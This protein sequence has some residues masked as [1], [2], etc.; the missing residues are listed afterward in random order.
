MNLP[1]K[2]LPVSTLAAAVIAA[3]ILA[4]P[5]QEARAAGGGGGGGGGGSSGGAGGGMTIIHAFTNAAM[6]SASL[7]QVGTNF[8]GTTAGNGG[9]VNGTLFKITATT[10]GYAFTNLSAFNGATNGAPSGPLVLSSGGILYG[11]T[12]MSVTNGTT[13]NYGSIFSLTPATGAF[14]TLATFNNA[15]G[16]NPIGGLTPGANDVYYGVTWSGGA[17]GLGTVFSWSPKGGLTNLFSFSGANGSYPQA[18]LVSNWDGNFYGTTSQGGANGFGTVFQLTPSG[19]VTSL[20]SFTGFNGSGPLGMVAVNSN[21]VGTT[22]YGGNY[23]LGTVFCVN[24]SGTLWLAASFDLANGSN[25]NS[26]L[27]LA[28]D[29]FLYGTTLQGGSNGK[30]V[31]FQVSTNGTA[32][33][34]GV[35][36]TNSSNGKGGLLTNV[37]TLSNVFAFDGSS[38][39]ANPMGGLIQGSDY[40]L[41]GTTTAGSS[42]GYGNVFSF[43]FPLVISKQPAD[44]TFTYKSNAVFSVQA[45]ASAGGGAGGLHYQWMWNGANITNTNYA[46]GVIFLGATTSKLTISNEVIYDVGSY[47]VVVSN[48][49]SVVT[50]AVAALSVPA[51]TN[52]ITSPKSKLV[53]NSATLSVTGSDKVVKGDMLTNVLYSLN[54]GPLTSVTPLPGI[55]NWTKWSNSV[56]LTPGSNT[57]TA[58]ALDA[59]GHSSQTSTV[60]VFYVTSSTL[61]LQTNGS[62]SIANSAQAPSLVIGSNSLVVA[63]NYTFK[64]VPSFD[65][66]FSNWTESYSTNTLTLT[67]NPLTF[68]M[69]SN[70]TLTANFVTNP[71]IAAGAAGAYC[72]L[73]YVTNSNGLFDVTNSAAADSSGLLQNLNVQTNGSY[74]A[75]LYIGGADFSI[76]GGFDLSG[77][78]T[79]QITNNSTLGP[80]TLKMYL[81][82]TN[83]PPQV[84]GS[85]SGTNGGAWT[86]SLTA[87]QTDTSLAA[88]E[89]NLLIPPMTNS[90]AGYG[91]AL[92][93]GNLG[94][95]ATVTG[96]LADGAAFSENTAISKT[97][98]L[99]I[100]AAPYSNGLLM[101]L[102]S[103]TNGVPRGNL[104]WIR[105]AAA[106]SLFTNGFAD[107]ILVQSQLWTNPP[108]NTPALPCSAGQLMISNSPNSSANL[109]FYVAV[110]NNNVLVKLG[111]KPTNSLSGSINPNTGLLTVTIGNGYGKPATTG[112]GIVLQNTNNVQVSNSVAGFIATATNTG[113][114]ILQTNLVNVAPIILR[115][116]AGAKF[117]SGNT[118]QFSVHAIGS[119]PLSY[120][121]QL[122]GTNLND[123]GEFSGSASNTLTVSN[124]TIYDAGTYSVIVTNTIKA[125]ASSNVFLTIPLPGIA[126]TSPKPKF[127]TNN[128]SLSV[129]GTATVVNGDTVTNVLYT[130]NN[131]PWTSA[132]QLPGTANWSNWTATVTLTP[133]SNIF[134]ACALDAL[135]NSSTN[136][137]AAVFYVTYSTLTLLTNGYGANHP[138]FANKPDAALRTNGLI[139]TNL[140]VGTNYTVT[141]VPKANNLFSNWTESY[142]TNTLTLTN[143]PLT[144][145]MQSNT[146]LTANFVTNPFMAAGAAG[147]YN[148]LFYVTDSNGAFDVTNGGAES[149]GLLG[150]L[151][152]GNMGTYSGKLYIGGTNYT[153]SGGFDLA[154]QANNQIARPAGLGPVSL[155]MNLSFTNN[156]PR[157]AGTVQGTN[158][159]AWTADLTAEMA[160]SNL[161]SAQYT[162][163]IPGDMEPL[164]DSPPGDG[165]ALITNHLGTVILTGALADGAS[166]SQTIAESENLRLPFYAAPYTNGLFTN[167]LL[168]GW[169]DLSGGAPA[170]SL[171]WIC[172]AGTSGLFTNGYTN[173]VTVQSSAWTD[174]GKTN[175]AISLPAGAPGYALDISYGILPPM[176]PVFTVIVAANNAIE[177]EGGFENATN[178]LSGSI[179]SK[180][181]KLTVIYGNGN[182]TNTTSAVGA[183]LQKQSMGGGFFTNATSAGAIILEPSF[184]P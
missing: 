26:P 60:A 44:A 18:G 53:T 45:T 59:L 131:G 97:G 20:A 69:E 164:A 133:G 153:V 183:I 50:S 21:L 49:S 46:D 123:V 168:T 122:D 81:N 132:T 127:V 14:S 158:G 23:D 61:T 90:P 120:Q 169:L 19:T 151:T 184:G 139:Y 121:W 63:T 154:G 94:G 179:D 137:A 159:G 118:V 15:N 155:A 11:A 78:A 176:G 129:T 25:P 88:A 140:I 134:M 87:E 83:S 150:N 116:P 178:F 145:T 163:L 65:N 16:A 156:P 149:S 51:P 28:A 157:I 170:G 126:I 35:V 143:N 2:L 72:G 103:F 73:F 30:G 125:V 42:D 104:N 8:Y 117:A 68:T 171:T 172:P 33:T 115:Q 36:W 5:A 147:I 182:G 138:G 13:N 77:N 136:C 32:G 89:Y 181:G 85:V 142:S 102:L 4:G 91:Y 175:P 43:S 17:Y 34:N 167:G 177:K 75:K 52:T 84:T 74:T 67:N 40:N 128:A 27:L 119:L 82:F 161:P 56:T 80:L 112:Y 146:T 160:G 165:Y 39:G 10:N 100:Y 79:N 148:G 93:A 31:L 111:G 66:L 58:H 7:V 24:T 3:V 110:T 105:P 98:N 70:M 174:L 180:T 22:Y 86:A 47:S 166:F 108:A 101:G 55:T 37:S 1:I 29:G 124:E 99:P 162:L 107:T 64:A 38:H 48:S 141:A 54:D 92:I 130:F 152:V 96:A 109:V 106:N 76:N 113:L 95:T 62:G 41:Y 9:S 173:V 135:G 57:I 144:F 71:F 114:L 12:L 6:P